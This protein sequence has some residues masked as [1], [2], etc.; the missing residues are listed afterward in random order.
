VNAS[1]LPDTITAPASLVVE[2]LAALEAIASY[3]AGR[4]GTDTPLSDWCTEKSVELTRAIFHPRLPDAEVP[5]GTDPTEVAVWARQYELEAELLE[6][7]DDGAKRAADS[8]R[9][10]AEIRATGDLDG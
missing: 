10:A 5:A 6:L 4:A 3:H 7:L 1:T 9:R 2:A 8:R